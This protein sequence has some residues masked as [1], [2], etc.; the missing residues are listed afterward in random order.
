MKNILLSIS[1]ILSL[2][3]FSQL[4][5][6][7]GYFVDNSN[8]KVTCYIKNYGWKNN[9]SEIEYKIS[10]DDEIQKRNFLSIKE[11]GIANKIKFERHTVNMDQSSGLINSL[12]SKKAPEF[13]N[14]QVLLKVLVDGHASLFSY[15]EGLLNR[16]FYSTQSGSVQPLVYKKY[17]DVENSVKENNRY[18]QQIYSDLK[19]QTISRENVG[20]LDYSSKD[21]TEIFIKFNE[22][23][24]ENY[25]VFKDNTKKDWFNLSL[26]P[27]IQQASL[28]IRNNNTAARNIGFGSQLGL[29][30]GVEF[31]FLLPFNK[32]KWAIVFEPTYQSYE[33]ERT[34]RNI[35]TGTVPIDD[36]VVVDY[37]S[38]ELPVGVRHYL[39]LTEK[40][41]LFLDA[42]LVFDAD[43]GSMVDFERFSDLEVVGSNNILFGFGYKYS[44][45]YSAQF[46]YGTSRN[47]LATQSAWD[48]DYETV[49]LIFGYTIF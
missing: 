7:K 5:F 33:A 35:P 21:L 27:G 18:K 30:I 12:S 36:E 16:Y 38:L 47:I 40:S 2:N 17:K 43:F 13:K 10:L 26:R 22:C 37:S 29:R 45:R 39:F 4:S 9:P 49:S 14:M 34:L 3:S 20:R 23:Q 19:C 15:K 8:Q 24:K 32:N 1:L 6:Q 25:I 28:S 44:N 11:F 46:R 31:E 48:S 42:S 41:K